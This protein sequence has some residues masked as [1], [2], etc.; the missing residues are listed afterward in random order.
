MC[1]NNQLSINKKTMKGKWIFSNE[2]NI[3]N[4]RFGDYFKVSHVVATLLNRAFVINEDMY[5][6][7]DD[8]F[9]VGDFFIEKDSIMST[10]TPRNMRYG[11]VEKI[12]FPYKYVDNQLTKYEEKE[13]AN[14]Y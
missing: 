8:Y 2:F 1:C 11:K 10:A 14:S 5:D 9:K 4:N 13:F 6:E 12:I 7:I 3:G